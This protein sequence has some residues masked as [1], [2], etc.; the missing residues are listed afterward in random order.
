ME[1]PQSAIHP[2]FYEDVG[3]PHAIL[4]LVELAAVGHGPIPP[5]YPVSVIM[6]N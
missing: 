3:R 6:P 5:K 1:Q 2:L 4:N